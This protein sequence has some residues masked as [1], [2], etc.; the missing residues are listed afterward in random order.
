MRYG[1]LGVTAI[2]CC[3]SCW[4]RGCM[5]YTTKTLPPTFS[6][7]IATIALEDQQLLLLG[8]SAA[9]SVARRC[10]AAAATETL[11]IRRCFC[12]AGHRIEQ[13]PTHLQVPVSD[14]KCNRRGAAG[15]S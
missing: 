11:T 13:P 14:S 6:N 5:P 10:I 15:S 7:Y 8:M 9:T 12:T 4:L 1:E 3:H 2:E